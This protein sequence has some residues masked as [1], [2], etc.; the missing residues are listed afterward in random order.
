MPPEITPQ[1]MVFE[2]AT[3][4]P[5]EITGEFTTTIRRA[6]RDGWRARAAEESIVGRAATK[7]WGPLHMHRT[8]WPGTP[9]ILHPNGIEIAGFVYYTRPRTA[10]AKLT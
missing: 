3:H 2:W 5:T 10:L 8:H 9:Y 4:E 6:N 7:H 1:D